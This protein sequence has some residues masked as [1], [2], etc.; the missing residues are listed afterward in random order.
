MLLEQQLELAQLELAKCHVVDE[1]PRALDPIWSHQGERGREP[2]FNPSE[3]RLDAGELAV[4]RAKRRARLGLRGLRR[5]RR[6]AGNPFPALREH[7]SRGHAG[8]SSNFRAQ[9][10]SRSG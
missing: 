8:S 9:M 3:V 10:I 1:V 5:H 4:D 7:R 2:L 6:Y